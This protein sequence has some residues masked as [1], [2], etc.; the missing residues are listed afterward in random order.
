MWQPDVSVG[1]LNMSTAI[2]GKTRGIA[3]AR[4][5]LVSV[6]LFIAAACGGPKLHELHPAQGSGPLT[7]Y[8]SSSPLILTGVVDAVDNVGW[9]H[10]TRPFHQVQLCRLKVN[11]EHV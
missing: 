4:E 9:S 8:L 7:R 11:V 5:L 6:P 3:L 10:E 1:Y 2:K